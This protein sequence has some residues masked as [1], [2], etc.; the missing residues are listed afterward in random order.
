MRCVRAGYFF[1]YTQAR[2]AFDTGLGLTRPMYYYFPEDDGAYPATMDANL[3]QLPS[4]RQYFFGDSL[5]VA[6][7]TVEG[8]CVAGI[9]PDVAAAIDGQGAVGAVAPSPPPPD[10]PCGLATM[11]CGC[12]QDHGLK[13]TQ[14]GSSVA[15][16]PPPRPHDRLAFI[17]LMCPPMPRAEPSS[18]TDLWTQ[19]SRPLVSRQT[20]TRRSND[21]LSGATCQAT[22][23]EDDGQTYTYLK[24]VTNAVP[25]TC[26]TSVLNVNT[27]T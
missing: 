2:V 4:S 1:I 26:S 17:F 15:R 18:L 8:V 11:A 10:A 9:A 5:L 22:V 7:V 20:H 27:K 3:G 19:A 16:A 13:S 23:Y 25:S 14:A 24:V 21:G 12:H 6:P